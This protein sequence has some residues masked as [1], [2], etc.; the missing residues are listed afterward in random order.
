MGLVQTRHQT[1][2]H[3]WV[4]LPVSVCWASSVTF[5]LVCTH[6][7]QPWVKRM[8]VGIFSGSPSHSL[9]SW[10]WSLQ[11][12]ATWSKHWI[13]FWSQFPTL[14][15]CGLGMANQGRAWSLADRYTPGW[16]GAGGVNPTPHT[17]SFHR[18]ASV[19]REV[20]TMEPKRCVGCVEP[21]KLQSLGEGK[22]GTGLVSDSKAGRVGGEWDQHCAR[23]L[24]FTAIHTWGYALAQ[25]VCMV[26]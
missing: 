12:S 19:F 23:L 6:L 14:L 10:Y 20:I 17:L 5:P 21:S 8:W 11:F 13:C 3:S 25:F 2:G 1:M 16:D 18:Q 4:R 9:W 7:Q 26:G 24:K 15:H 22:Q